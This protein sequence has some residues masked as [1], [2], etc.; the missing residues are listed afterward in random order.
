MNVCGGVLFGLRN[1]E[2]LLNE[3]VLVLCVVVFLGGGVGDHV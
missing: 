3:R 1:G 2:Y